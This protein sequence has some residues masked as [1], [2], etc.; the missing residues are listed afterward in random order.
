GAPSLRTVGG[1]GYGP[2]GLAGSSNVHN[3]SLSTG[4][5][6]TFSTSLLGDF[7]FGYFKYNPVASKPDAGTTPMT[8]VG[9]PNANLT[10]SQAQET[11]G[12]GGFILNQT[13]S[14]SSG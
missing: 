12:W 1:I 13:P 7:R 4:V 14:A 3:Y 5:T 2:G 6:K 11:S 8:A 9:I 10:G